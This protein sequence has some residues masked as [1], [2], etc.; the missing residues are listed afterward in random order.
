MTD[1]LFSKEVSKVSNLGAILSSRYWLRLHCVCCVLVGLV[2][3]LDLLFLAVCWVCLLVLVE[4]QNEW[5][6]SPGLDLTVCDVYLPASS[7]HWVQWQGVWHFRS[8]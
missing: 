2:F 3:V 7:D 1:W 5:Q 6:T 4:F 8:E